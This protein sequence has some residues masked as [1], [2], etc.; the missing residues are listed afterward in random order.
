MRDLSFAFLEMNF[1]VLP[2]IWEM[3]VR[4][5]PFTTTESERDALTSCIFIAVVDTIWILKD[6][7]FTFFTACY[8]DKVHKQNNEMTLFK[9]MGTHILD[10][11]SK[12]VC[13]TPIVF[14]F[15]FGYI[16]LEGFV[17]TWLFLAFCTYAI[18]TNIIF[19]C[20]VQPHFE[21]YHPLPEGTLRQCIET[22]AGVTKFPLRELAVVRGP[23]KGNA[24]KHLKITGMR[25]GRRLVLSDTLLPSNWQSK[26]SRAGGDLQ[27]DCCSD[28]EIVAFFSH[29]IAHWK[30][31]HK[32]QQLTTRLIHILWI[33]LILT[34]LIMYEPLYEAVGFSQKDV[35]IAVSVYLV[36]RFVLTP[37][38]SF[39][40]F[41]LAFLFRAFEFQADEYVKT[42]GFGFDL[43]RALIRMYNPSTEFP[44]IDW[45]YSALKNTQPNTMERV[46]ALSPKKDQ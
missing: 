39:I 46:N 11:I 15:H 6:L 31:T 1:G 36:L 45:F 16:F 3:S 25:G 42:L 12:R 20:L 9:H 17:F 29:E 27:T 37:I 7:P 21:E 19:P 24:G 40:N 18:W 2:K 33:F 32:Y 8:V 43:K 26:D 13:M 34:S 14:G 22:I 4:M 30:F 28:G 10:M 5:T 23:L 38:N 35:P 44:Y 41:A